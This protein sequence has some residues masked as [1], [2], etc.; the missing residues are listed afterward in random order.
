[1]PQPAKVTFVIHSFAV[2]AEVGGNISQPTSYTF[3]VTLDTVDVVSTDFNA[4]PVGQTSAPQTVNFAFDQFEII[5]AGGDTIATIDA[6]TLGITGLDYA[7]SNAGTCAVGTALTKTSTCSMQVTFTP[8]HAGQRKG[9][10]ILL[11]P[12]GNGIGEAY[13]NG[14]G[15]APQVTFTPYTPVNFTILPPQNNPNAGQGSSDR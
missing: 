2:E 8:S 10:I 15:T 13:L 3:T 6:T 14:T 11:D 1:M 9:A 12:A 4:V 5:P 7:V